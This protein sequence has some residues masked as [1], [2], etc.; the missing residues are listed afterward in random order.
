MQ[1]CGF[2]YLWCV[3]VCGHA[4]HDWHGG[5]KERLLFLIFYSPNFLFTE[6]SSE[7]AAGVAHDLPGNRTLHCWPAHCASEWSTNKDL[8]IQLPYIISW[9]INLQGRTY[10]SSMTGL[11][12]CQN[13]SIRWKNTKTWTLLSVLQCIRDLI[14]MIWDPKPSDENNKR[15]REAHL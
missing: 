11:N 6:Y 7:C 15:N 1:A 12:Y 10:C 5:Q 9:D 14:E 8:D 2:M 3:M 4:V 13:L